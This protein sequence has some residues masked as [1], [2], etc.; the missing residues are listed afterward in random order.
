MNHAAITPNGLIKVCKLPY[1]K[2]CCAKLLNKYKKEGHSL[3]GALYM[4]C[5]INNVPYIAEKVRAT[6][7]Y[8]TNEAKS[9]KMVKRNFAQGI[10]SNDASKINGRYLR[11]KQKYLQVR[12]QYF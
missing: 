2:D 11:R 9:G 8:I 3:E 1:C 12:T 5:A 10:H 4:T 7:E 6:F